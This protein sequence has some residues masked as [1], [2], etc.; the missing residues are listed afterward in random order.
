VLTR[1]Y[2]DTTRLEIDRQI[3][4]AP[5]DAQR[6]AFRGLALAYLGRR[7]EAIAD[8]ERAVA[9][10]PIARDAFIGPYIQHQLVRIYLLAGKPEQAL[11]RLEPLLQ[12][13][14]LL[15][16]ARLRVDPNFA[17]LRGNPRF[18]RLLAA[19]VH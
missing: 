16:P 9:L 12:L 11:D 13:P 17:P 7:E 1:A 19:R 15:S 6:H 8:G 2:A 5:E 3:R 14:Y 18:E 4:A 10:V